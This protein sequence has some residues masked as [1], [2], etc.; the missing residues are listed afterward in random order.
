M[1]S[2]IYTVRVG[3]NLSGGISRPK[4]GKM[5]DSME[6]FQIRGSIQV[7]S[8]VVQLVLQLKEV[9]GVQSSCPRL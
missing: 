6:C 1:P 7:R 8:G 3:P 4:R 9:C 2:P 5:F